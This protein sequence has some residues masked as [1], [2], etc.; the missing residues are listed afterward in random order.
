MKK[1]LLFFSFAAL[2]VSADIVVVTGEN[3]SKFEK[4]AAE[5][6]MAF[7]PQISGEKCRISNRESAG[8]KNIFLGDTAEARAAGIDVSACGKEQWVLDGDG[9]RLIISGGRPIGTL[10]GVYAFL[11]KLGVRFFAWDTVKVPQSSGFQIPVIREKNEPDFGGRHIFDF[12]PIAFHR[13]KSPEALQK[14]KMH[15]LRNNFNGSHNN[16]KTFRDLY[17]GDLFR[18]CPQIPPYHNFY[19][20]LPPQKYFAAHPEYFSM[21]A[22]GKRFHGKPQGANFCMTNKDVISI[23]TD[24]LLKFIRSDREKNPD[25]P[26]MVYDISQMDQTSFMCLCPSCKKIADAEGDCGLLLTFINQ[27]AENISREYPEIII[28]T[29][30]YSSTVEPP[31]TIRPRSN[32]LIQYCDPY[33]KSDCFRPLGSRFNQEYAALLERWQRTGSNMMVWDYWNMGMGS[34]FNP[35]R[36]EVIIDALQSDFRRFHDSGIKAVFIEAERCF[37]SPQNFIDLEYYLAG[38]LMVD[39]NADVEKIIDEFI[40]GYYGSAAAEMK[41]YLNILREGVAA[42]PRRQ[43]MMQVGDWQFLTPEK[44]LYIH[45]LLLQAEKKTA[46]GS[47]EYYHVR[48]ERITP[49]WFTL[50]QRDKTMVVF[51]AKGFDKES[52]F[53]ELHT[54]VIE[55]VNRYQG[56]NP[57]Y[58]TGSFEPRYQALTADLR[59]PEKFAGIPGVK[60]FGWPHRVVSVTSII[61]DDKDASTGKVVVSKNASGANYHGE[62]TVRSL[63]VTSCGIWSPGVCSKSVRLRNLPTDGKFHWYVLRD[64]KLGS[65]SAFWAHL[66]KIQINLA[67]AFRPEDN[68]PDINRYDLHFYIR[69]TGPAYIPGD[70]RENEIAVDKVVLVPI[71]KK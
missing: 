33:M 53:K 17:E 11:N 32:V 20:Y 29:F 61:K 70:T 14:W 56:A 28:R 64:V 47:L 3:P 39:R 58:L 38:R 1:L 19:N 45:E 15:R 54:L 55:Q 25:D 7:L 60:V 50:Y 65:K 36:P 34:F 59:I 51:S 23:V 63:P 52:L 37:D 2:T 27:V 21:D 30:A 41:E 9:K 48:G 12:Y 40:S 66:W 57:Q 16:Q 5:E 22:K 62:D 24:S 69:F 44:L 49:L 43:V 26:P 18:L 42:E 46:P 31:K 8:D 68:N 10:Y 13:L 6:L 4:I 71:R 35:P 67:S